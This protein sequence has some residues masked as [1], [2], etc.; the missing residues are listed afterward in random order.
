MPTHDQPLYRRIVTGSAASGRSTIVSDDRLP[1]S[2]VLGIVDFWQTNAVPASL[3]ES[4][5]AEATPK[6]LPSA[7][8]T[9]FR[10]F[11]I[12]A[13]TN[14]ASH[15]E[16][17]EQAKQAFAAADAADC[18]VDTTRHPMMHCTETIDYVVLLRGN[19]TLILDDAEID[20]EPFDAVVQR[21]AN[22]YW[23]NSADTPALFLGVLLDAKST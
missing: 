13:L 1:V 21:G 22:H 14:A 11:E 12:P 8:G 15:Q 4:W 3:T 23:V 5:Q 19:V 6:L 16:L 7:G 17:V 2:N 10:F 18:Q 20:L 9:I